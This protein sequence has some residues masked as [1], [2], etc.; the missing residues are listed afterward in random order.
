[1]NWV[2]WLKWRPH[3]GKMFTWT[4]NSAVDVPLAIRRT[5]YRPA[6][7]KANSL[8]PHSPPSKPPL[9]AHQHEWVTSHTLEAEDH[10]FPAFQTVTGVWSDVACIT[11]YFEELFYLRVPQSF[12]N[13]YHLRLNGIVV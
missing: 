7:D 5:E 4:I 3:T 10:A 12:S 6:I 9:T 1:M 11:V 13:E 8:V 2:R